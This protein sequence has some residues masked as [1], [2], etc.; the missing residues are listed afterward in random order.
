MKYQ[1]N[2]PT[3]LYNKFIENINTEASNYK[4]KYASKEYDVLSN[5]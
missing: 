2:I 1:P 4:F 5:R 3:D